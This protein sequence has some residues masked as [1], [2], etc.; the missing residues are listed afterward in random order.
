MPADS[1]FK[2]R[3]LL[4]AAKTRTWPPSIVGLLRDEG[5]RKMISYT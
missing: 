2:Q 3:T 5:R 1:S 4:L